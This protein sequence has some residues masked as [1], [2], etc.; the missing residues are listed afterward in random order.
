[1][2]TCATYEQAENGASAFGCYDGHDAVVVDAGVDPLLA[3]LLATCV[4]NMCVSERWRFL[5]IP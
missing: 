4:E 2:G 1:M 3:V 5:L